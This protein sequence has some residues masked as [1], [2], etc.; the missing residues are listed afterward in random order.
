MQQ[1]QAAPVTAVV[2]AEH[3]TIVFRCPAST[4]P[5]IP[6]PS[7]AR[8]QLLHDLADSGGAADVSEVS[9]P[10]TWAAL[11]QW[12][13]HIQVRSGSGTAP[14]HPHPA[15]TGDAAGGSPAE[16][17]SKPIALNGDSAAT[18]PI[19]ASGSAAKALSGEPGGSPGAPG[20]PVAIQHVKDA[21]L[22]GSV[23]EEDACALMSVR[24]RTYMHAC[25]AAWAAHRCWGVVCSHK[26]HF[27]ILVLFSPSATQRNLCADGALA[28]CPDL[29]FRSPSFASKCSTALCPIWFLYYLF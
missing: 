12:L 29:A 21:G 20:G 19:R 23:S 1:T 16:S 5:P 18:A 4:S 2:S 24:S 13:C 14:T 15:Q 17:G 22:D 27:Q 6:L 25:G 9:V 26:T 7:I 8:S 3:G 28:L 11:Q 10:V